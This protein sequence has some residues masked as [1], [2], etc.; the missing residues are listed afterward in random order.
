MHRGECPPPEG[1]Q[2]ALFIMINVHGFELVL[3]WLQVTKKDHSSPMEQ[4]YTIKGFL[5]EDK[6]AHVQ[7]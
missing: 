3:I 1:K 7:N 6:L 2:R 5:G 4:L